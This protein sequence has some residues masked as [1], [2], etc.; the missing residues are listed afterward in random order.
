MSTTSSA[1]SAVGMPESLGTPAV[2][3]EEVTGGLASVQSEISAIQARF[4]QLSQMASAP[5]GIGSFQDLVDAFMGTGSATS[6]AVTSTGGT[7]QPLGPTGSQVVA[8]AE[9]YLGVRYTWGGTSRTTGFD[10]SGLVQHVY[11]ALGIQLP[12]TSQEQATVGQPVAGLASAQP[13]DLV[14]FEP[15]PG[16]P[17]HVGI[18]IGNGEMI[19]APYTGTVVQ[20]QPVGNPYEI[21]R[22]LPAPGGGTGTGT[23]VI[24]SLAGSTATSGGSAT[25]G[26]GLGSIPAGLAPLFLSAAG[27]YGIPPQLLAAVAQAE[28]GF[29][30]NAV[31]SA[32]AEGIMQL[33]PGT[34]AGLGVDPFNPAQAIDAAAQLLS[35][36]ISQF[37]SVPLALA[38]YNAGPGAVERYGG[39]PPYAQTQSYVQEVMSYAGY[40]PGSNP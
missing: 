17:G 13:G 22:V 35:G 36:Y 21:R 34:A 19:D 30:P 26:A 37:G 14:F 5:T 23:G 12:R 15:G 39:I 33:M 16:G 38:A 3:S 29:N 18:Y 1:I 40:Q 8:E 4:S 24:T 9:R 32:G 31:S 20:I 10:C 7:S 27:R 28:S 2:S 25:P 6:S 11:A